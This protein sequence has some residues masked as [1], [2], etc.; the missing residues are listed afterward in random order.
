[1]TRD[2][3]AGFSL[4]EVLVVLALLATMASA[5]FISFGAA[6]RG[7]G[8]ETEAMLLANRLSLAFDEALVTGNQLSLSLDA[9]GYGVDVWS[10]ESNDWVPHPSGLFGARHE[11]PRGIRM[12]VDKRLERIPI[13][14]DATGEPVTITLSNAAS[15]WNVS[16]D[17]FSA[18]AVPVA[19]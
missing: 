13:R 12:E 9:N 18:R 11:M 17:G 10:S 16:H 6:N 19:R 2:N 7:A 4:V 14:P 15:G 8:P 1:M 5:T 3:E